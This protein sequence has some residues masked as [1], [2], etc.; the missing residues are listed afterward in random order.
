M[1]IVN[2]SSVPG[3]DDR[4]VVEE[5][6]SSTRQQQKETANKENRKQSASDVQLL[7]TDDLSDTTESDGEKNKKYA[8]CDFNSSH[9]FKLL[10][11]LLLL[12]SPICVELHE[13]KLLMNETVQMHVDHLFTLLFTSSKFFLDFHASRKTTDLTQTAWCQNSNG[14]KSRIV[15]LTV[16]LNQTMG[17]KTSQVTETQVSIVLIELFLFM[18]RESRNDPSNQ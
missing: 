2:L 10:L 15:N 4:K 17:P 13:G 1:S 3:V 14:T 8:D 6:T 7:H 11:N 18:Y 9:S 5:D 16:A 12:F